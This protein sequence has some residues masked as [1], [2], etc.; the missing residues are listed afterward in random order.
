G[1]VSLKEGANKYS[2]IDSHY[3]RLEVDSCVGGVVDDATNAKNS[4]DLEIVDDLERR[5]R[6]DEGGA[7][8]RVSL[9]AVH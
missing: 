7:V 8:N 2:V 6:R 5:V 3:R 1:F 9:I 4:S